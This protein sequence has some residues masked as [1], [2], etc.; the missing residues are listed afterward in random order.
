MEN[1]SINIIAADDHKIFLAGIASLFESIDTFQLV[2][3]GNDGDELLMLCDSLSP[4]IALL[5][6]SMPGATTQDIINVIT[7][8]HPATKLIALSMYHDPHEARL[9]IQSGLSG[10]VLKESAFDDLTDAI[11]HVFLGKTFISKS[12]QDAIN[13][14]PLD[15]TSAF[16]TDREKLI[17]TRAAH[18][19]SNQKIAD[20]IGISE[21]TVRFHL[22]N[23]CEKLNAHGRSNA[24]AMALH[25]HLIELD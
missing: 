7:K 2:G 14:L 19:N 3:T 9:L 8:Q 10:Y 23:C 12:L 18:G 22:S 25:R 5:D 4:D 11:N 21:R 20:L 13:A 16:L 17:L 6:L 1:T 24:I 15:D